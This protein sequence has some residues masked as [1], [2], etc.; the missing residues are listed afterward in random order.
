VKSSISEVDLAF[1]RTKKR[2]VAE[3]IGFRIVRLS[4]PVLGERRLLVLLLEMARV[5]NRLAFEASGRQLGDE[6]HNNA[7]ALDEQLLLSLVPDGGRVVDVGCGTGRWSRVAAQKAGWVLG[8]DFD[9]T[10]IAVARTHS[11]G[12]PVAYD[13]SDVTQMRFAEPV[14]LVLLIHV[15][16]HIADPIAL[17]AALHPKVL[18]LVVEVPEFRADPLNLVRRHLRVP[19]Y[20]DRDHVREYIEETLVS[21]LSQAGWTV[22]ATRSR[23]GGLMAVAEATVVGAE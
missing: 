12:L 1:G 9:E 7:M 11:H 20:S 6:F 15:L 3:V 17:L 21:H 14:D 22:V 18:R 2:S 10:A 13:T 8:V 23:G 19:F 16:E 5:V 4:R